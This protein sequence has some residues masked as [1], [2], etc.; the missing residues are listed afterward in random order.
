MSANYTLN[1]GLAAP[2]GGFLEAAVVLQV[3][4]GTGF[5]VQRSEVFDSDTEPTLVVS[6]HSAGDI[7]K[8]KDWPRAAY[9]VAEALGQD[10]IAVYCDDLGAGTL[11]GPCAPKWGDFNPKL[12]ITIDGARLG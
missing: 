4:S 6:G 3:L 7:F 12:F 5:F 10:C 1:I 8:G 9:R 2:A 11:I